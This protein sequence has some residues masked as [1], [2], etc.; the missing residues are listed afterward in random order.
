[1]DQLG[2]AKY[3]STLDLTQGYWQVP[4]A[5]HA[6]HKTAFATPFGLYHLKRMPFGLQW[7]PATFQRMM[8]RLLDGCCHFASAYL[9]DLVIFSSSWPEHLQHLRAVCQRLKG[10][11]LT[12]KPRKCSVC[13]WDTLW[14][15]DKLNW[16]QPKSKQYG[17]SE[18]RGQ[19]RRSAH[20]WAS[21]GTTGSLYPI[22]HQWQAP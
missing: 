6:Q 7:A 10:A 5:Q 20:S 12:A 13:I 16:K 4:V 19:R 22:I 9:D 8:D 2:G 17:C 21:L 14:G 3:I 1:M 11:G 18:S 15:E